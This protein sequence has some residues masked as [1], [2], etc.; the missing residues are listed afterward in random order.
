MLKKSEAKFS[1]VSDQESHN[2]HCRTVNI[3]IN[4][5]ILEFQNN[6]PN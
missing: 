1:K 4:K 3:N 6:I 2:S 5:S